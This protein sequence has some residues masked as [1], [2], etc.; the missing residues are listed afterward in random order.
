MLRGEGRCDEKV[1]AIKVHSHTHGYKTGEKPLIRGI[2]D[3]CANGIVRSVRRAVILVR[4]PYHAIWSSYQIKR[5]RGYLTERI[6]REQF[7]KI[8]WI[9]YAMKSAI[10]YAALWNHY[11]H[12]KRSLGI[13]HILVIKYEVLE[14]KG[15]QM[16]ELSKLLKFMGHSVSEN[17]KQCAFLVSCKS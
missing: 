16:K 3:P 17:R 14:S 1:A 9:E 4:N 8:S 11:H 5:S 6:Q 13:N 15:F 12:M 2:S 7:D 10:D